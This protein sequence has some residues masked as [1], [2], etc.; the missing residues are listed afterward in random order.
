MYKA[1]NFAN[2]L[3][4]IVP[5]HDESH[6]LEID[7]LVS[8]VG[9]EDLDKCFTAV[10]RY[11]EKYP[12]EDFGAPGTLVHF[13]ETGYPRYM[14]ALCESLDRQPSTNTILMAN[15]I[16]NSGICASE[17]NAL[18]S[19]LERISQRDDVG[20]ALRN[21]AAHFMEFQRKKGI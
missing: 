1:E 12:E 14:E 7:Q 20:S 10:F 5:R 17:R 2:D 21:E 13:V 8:K 9:P 4:Q 6:L 19:A 15:R 11:F 3:L 16:L 18:M